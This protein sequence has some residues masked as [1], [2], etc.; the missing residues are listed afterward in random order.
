MWK[1]H[2]QVSEPMGRV[3]IVSAPFDW[4]RPEAS[5]ALTSRCGH[6]VSLIKA[7]DSGQPR[8]RP[9]GSSQKDRKERRTRG[10]TKAVR[11]EV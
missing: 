5:S 1:L 11:S 9:R 2:R 3:P 8:T 6:D 7:W 4:I 10:R